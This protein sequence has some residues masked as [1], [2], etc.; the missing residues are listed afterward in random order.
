MVSV[1]MAEPQLLSTL[2][3]PHCGHHATEHMPTDACV[4]VYDC[5][6]CGERLKPLPGHCCGVLLL[7]FSSVPAGPAERGAVMLVAAAMNRLDDARFVLLRRFARR[8]LNLS[9]SIER[10]VRLPKGFA[11]EP[12]PVKLYPFQKVIVDS[13]RAP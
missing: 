6:G 10:V 12:G 7:W 8:P 4:V 3:C 13:R 2:T 9:Q 1:Q 5:T 11:A